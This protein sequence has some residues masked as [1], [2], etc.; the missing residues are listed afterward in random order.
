MIKACLYIE[1]NLLLQSVTIIS[2]LQTLTHRNFPWT[3]CLLI[4]P[5]TLWSVQH[6][7]LKGSGSQWQQIITYSM[8]LRR[9]GAGTCFETVV[10][11]STPICYCSMSL[12]NNWT[13]LWQKTLFSGVPIT[14]HQQTGWGAWLSWG[15]DRSIKYK[16]YMENPFHMTVVKPF[17]TFSK[18]DRIVKSP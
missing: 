15:I 17:M 14:R 16:E 1:S 10:R 13:A 18:E 5:L 8:K 11:D 6:E 9:S 7:S 4:K 2:N 12:N 3:V